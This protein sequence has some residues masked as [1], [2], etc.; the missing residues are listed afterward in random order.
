MVP[1]RNWDT[2]DLSFWVS[3]SLMAFPWQRGKIHRTH[4][5]ALL[6]SILYTIV[7]DRSRVDRKERTFFVKV[8]SGPTSAD[9]EATIA[10]A[11]RHLHRQILGNR[12]SLARSA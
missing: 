10:D 2:Y 5:E 7:L 1:P 4:D 9:T 8:A 3:H 11:F 12:D 6:L